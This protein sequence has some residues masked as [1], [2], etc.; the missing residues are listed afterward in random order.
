[1]CL[2]TTHPHA[3][4]YFYLHSLTHAPTAVGYTFTSRPTERYP[5]KG[6]DGRGIPASHSLFFYSFPPQNEQQPPPGEKS[7]WKM[8]ACDQP[9]HRPAPNTP[10]EINY[11]TKSAHNL[12]Q[13]CWCGTYPSPG[14]GTGVG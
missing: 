9:P 10:R 8:G 14:L 1:M 2:I 13:G 11:R 6:K 4:T 5:R 3:Y 12:Q 7:S